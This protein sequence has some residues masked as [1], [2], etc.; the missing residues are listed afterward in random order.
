MQNSYLKEYIRIY[1]WQVLSFVLN[2]IALFIVVPLLSNNADIYGV[3]T[4]CVSMTIFLSYADLGFISA[5]VKFAS[6]AF[7]KHDCEEEKKYI[8]LSIFVYSIIVSLLFI[9]FVTVSICPQYIISGI[10]ID[11]NEFY[12]ARYL[13]FILTLS[14]PIT[15]FQKYL[16]MVYGVR[17]KDYEIQKVNILGAIIRI[18]SVPLVFFND[19][20][21]IVG[22]YAFTQFIFLFCVIVL[23]YKARKIGF[24]FCTFFQI[25]RFNKET[26]NKM[27]GLAIGGTVSSISWILYYELDTITIGKLFGVKAVAI[28][29][30]GLTVLSFLRSALSIL[31]SPYN[32]RFN[33]F[34]GT[35]DFEGLKKFY[36]Y[37]VRNLSV[38]VVIPIFIFILFARPFVISWVGEDY[39]DSVIILQ[40]L[41][42]CYL[43]AF[44]SNPSSY[45]QIALNRIRE[46]YIVS[47]L[48]PFIFWIGVFTTYSFY[49]IKSFAFFKMLAFLISGIYY[50]FF[51]CKILNIT[52]CDYVKDL[53]Y[54][55]LFVILISC[56]CLS[57][58]I[59]PQLT[60]EK[61]KL[62][63]LMVFSFMAV[64]FLFILLIHIILN[65]EFRQKAF[66]V[67]NIVKIK[68]FK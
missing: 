4:I 30:I 13:L 7:G 26:F 41:L 67:F 1:L 66:D 50:M 35:G 19:Q 38:I 12:I 40:L 42:S 43:V 22:Y 32:V 31:Y 33:Y 6:E 9:F 62:D 11:T 61:S 58:M 24:G 10:S 15:V 54:K 56:I 23:M 65:R 34:I 49:G 16:Q 39:A 47:L 57:I 44:I 64:S 59:V 37:I 5:G 52:F 45:L 14:I 18:A 55:P 48:L 3:Y 21:D 53:I 28:Y 27:K 51:S 68:I 63:L 60:V 17:L 36:M 8:G 29:A 20:Y 25:W 46:I 2:F